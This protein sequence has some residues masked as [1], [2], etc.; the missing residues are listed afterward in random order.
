MLPY[1]PEIYLQLFVPYNQAVWP[2][3]LVLAIG[4]FAGLLISIGYH[5][6]GGRIFSALL[7]IS[8]FVVGWFFYLRVLFDLLWLSPVP[9]VFCLLQALL[10]LWSGLIRNR[11][12]IEMNM[13]LSTIAGILLIV[14][15]TTCYP[16][17]SLLSD[18]GL[19]LTQFA[20][21]APLPTLVLTIGIYLLSVKT[22]PVILTIIPALLLVFESLHTY[23]MYDSAVLCIAASGLFYLIICLVIRRS[24]ER[25]SV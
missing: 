17:L 25:R 5:E 22:L 2:F 3:Q 24:S 6:A 12:T 1:S 13:N 7:A 10:L 15:A 16:V 21:L 9:A 20:G 19:V 11:M 14:F 4:I 8:Y 23:L 18:Q